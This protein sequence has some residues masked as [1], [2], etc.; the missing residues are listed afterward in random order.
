[1]YQSR[2]RYGQRSRGKY[3]AAAAA[4]A[5]S[6]AILCRAGGSAVALSSDH[7]PDGPLELLRILKAS[8][9]A[10]YIHTYIHTYIYI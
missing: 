3:P 8:R 9:H 2:P 10:R 1:M 6:R 7:K 4:A 5:R